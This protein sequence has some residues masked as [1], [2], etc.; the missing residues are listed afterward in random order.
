MEGLLS[1]GAEFVGMGGIDRMHVIA[2][3]F[4]VFLCAGPVHEN[5]VEGS[6]S[7]NTGGDDDDVVFDSN[8]ELGLVVCRGGARMYSRDPD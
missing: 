5:E 2:F 4:L 7:G 8:V 6:K 1:Y 3:S